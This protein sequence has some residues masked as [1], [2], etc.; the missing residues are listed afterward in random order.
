VGVLRAG[1][2][3][4]H[5]SDGGHRWLCPWRG[6]TTAQEAAWLAKVRAHQEAHRDG[7]GD[8]YA[9]RHLGR[10]LETDAGK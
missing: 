2:E 5:Y 3:E 8:R 4:L 7:L 9:G 10:L 1:E 6:A